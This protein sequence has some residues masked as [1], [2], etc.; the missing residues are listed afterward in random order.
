MV[1]AI[2][3][4]AS[5]GV[6]EVGDPM[7]RCPKG[8]C[9]LSKSEALKLLDWHGGQWSGAYALGSSSFAGR[10]VPVKYAERALDELRDALRSPGRV[11]WTKRESLHLI[12]RIKAVA[13]AIRSA[14][15]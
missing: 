4:S 7:K 2:E 6:S 14:K 3:G 11:T 8:E 10:C 1:E 9:R 5:A 12:N 13:A 15:G